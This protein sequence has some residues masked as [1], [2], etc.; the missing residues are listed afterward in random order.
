MEIWAAL[1]GPPKLPAAVVDAIAK[2]AT[3][4]LTDKAFV[5]RRAKMGDQTP[6]VETP[7]E[8]ARFLAAEEQRYRTLA[9]G[10]KLE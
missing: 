6:P 4:L 9:T 3:A 7:A 8:F 10:M 5:E 2:A 1:A